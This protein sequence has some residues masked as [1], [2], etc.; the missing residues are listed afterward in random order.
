MFQMSD[1]T[2]AVINV[3]SGYFTVILDDDCSD[4]NR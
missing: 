3:H 2:D 4:N 1:Q